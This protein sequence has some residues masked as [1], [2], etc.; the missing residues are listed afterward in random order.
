MDKSSISFR[1]PTL[2]ILYTLGFIFAFSGA[3]P[4]YISS[5]FLSNLTGEE[6]VGLVYT[7]CS[8][9]TLITFILVPKF[10]KKYGNY[11]ATLILSIIN[12]LALF[13]LALFNNVYAIL[14]CFASSYAS[15]TILGFCLDIFIEHDSSNKDT[16]NI[17]GIYL[18]SV[19]L[20]WLIAPWLSAFILGVSDYW[21]VYLASSAIMIPIV[22]M[23]HS[24]LG[25]FVDPIYEEFNI[26]KTLKE[27]WTRVDVRRIFASSILLQF[28]YAW[29]VIYAPIYLYKYIG[30]DWK[31]IAVI[32]TIML[33]PF[34]I[35]QI[36]LGQL[37]DRMLGEKEMLSVGFIIM[38]ISTALISFIDGKNFWIW[39]VLLLFTRIG[40]SIVQL[41][42]DVYFFKNISEKNVSL[43]SLYRMTFPATY[44]FAPVLGTI[45][46]IY[47]PFIYMFV[48]LGFIMLFGLVYSLAIKDTR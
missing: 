43:I 35:L 19:N 48:T 9:I 25:T 23:V 28:F 37:A 12:L 27:A 11:K 7:A 29:M 13:G 16:G 10:I 33:L 21:K 41:M 40:A 22:L 38:A 8:V 47:F 34:V 36:P 26:V 17:R 3:L 44:I 18:T 6:F 14:I 39:A 15:G 2:F 24:N 20:A 45:F 30:F 32:F 31:T 1:G 4:S 42:A 5:T 46:L